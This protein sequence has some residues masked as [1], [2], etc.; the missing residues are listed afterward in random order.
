M[1]IKLVALTAVALL[2]LTACSSGAGSKS[3]SATATTSSSSGKIAV[4]LPDSKSSARWETADRVFFQ[5]TFEAAG[6]SKSDF[7]ISNAEGDPSVQRTQADQAITNGAKVLI[8][9]NLDNGSGTAII[10]AAHAQG[11]TVID[12]DRMTVGGKADYYVSGDATAAGRLQGKGLVEDLKNV[13]KPRVAILDGAPTDS[14][15]TD[16]AKGY[17]EV[18]NPLF[19]S[20][21]FIK[22]ADQPVKDWDGATALT[23]FEQML[24]ASNN[25][26]DGVIAANDT[27]ANAVI[28]TLKSHKLPFLPVS[29]LDGEV[30]AL[31]HI[32]A[33][34]QTF[35]V[36]FSYGIQ[37]T[38]AGNL[39][40]E[41]LRG[42]APTG[43]S[44]S[45]DNAG[46]SVPAMMINPITVRANNIAETVIADGLI[47][48]NDICIG[49]YAKF[50]PA[51]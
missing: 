41:L 17:G 3:T 14:F 46:R 27:I 23:I 25:K 32:L 43:I 7:I 38:L 4:L 9:V 24:T 21:Q 28:S 44:N 36:Y 45:V 5:K 51:H 2:L 26:I 19:K 37:A 10:D 18:L 49:D 29:G 35:T 34:E 40:V 39:A 15:A 16:L 8:L 33:K 48:W 30:K 20:G 12:Y 13:V 22:V 11:V 6:L 50:C 42:K 47:T 31:Q 1:R